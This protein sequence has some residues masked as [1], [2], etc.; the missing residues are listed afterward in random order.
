M[1]RV[2]NGSD[3]YLW[4][5]SPA[6]NGSWPLTVSVWVKDELAVTNNLA[7]VAVSF[8]NTAFGPSYAWWGTLGNGTNRI[9]RATHAPSTLTNYPALG[10]VPVEGVWHH[11]ASTGDATGKTVYT[12][13]ADAQQNTDNGDDLVSAPNRFAIGVL[14]RNT[15]DAPF[16]GVVAEVGVWDVVLTPEEIA[17]L[18]TGRRP[19]YVRPESLIAYYPLVDDDVDVISSNALTVEGT[20]T[21]GDHPAMDVTIPTIT[22]TSPTDDSSTTEN[23]ILVEGTADD[24]GSPSFGLA[25]VEV[26]VNGGDWELSTGTTSWS[27]SVSLT[28]G[29]N[30]IEAR[31][32]DN[33]ENISELDAITV[34]RSGVE[35]EEAEVRVSYP[36]GTRG[37]LLAISSDPSAIETQWQFTDHDGR[38]FTFTTLSGVVNA[39]NVLNSSLSFIEL[40]LPPYHRYFLRTRQL[41]D[42]SWGEWSDYLGFESRGPLNSYENFYAI[43]SKYITKVG[44]VVLDY[45]PPDGVDTSQ[46]VDRV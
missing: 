36:V 12:D 29:S 26:R 28:L 17:D 3:Q 15:I 9:A 16:G 37:T 20:P 19:I 23:S 45:A 11:I 14:F 46:N 41:T 21:F 43:S 27:H 33:E 13:G 7:G 6:W 35:V 32:T 18:A 22:I 25:S 31:S 44:G 42:G 40:W 24:P 30:N 1:G 4:T 8:G 10:T 34:T 5:S 39:D 38:D 2:F